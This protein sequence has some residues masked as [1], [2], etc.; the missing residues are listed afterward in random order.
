MGIGNPWRIALPS[1]RTINRILERNDL[2]YR[3]TGKYEPKGT[4]YSKHPFL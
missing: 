1:L 2:T 4:P 3:R